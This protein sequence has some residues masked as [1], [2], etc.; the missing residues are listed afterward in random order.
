MLAFGALV[1][2]RRGG[3]EGKVIGFLGLLSI[4]TVTWLDP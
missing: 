3:W 2:F 4:L 1:D